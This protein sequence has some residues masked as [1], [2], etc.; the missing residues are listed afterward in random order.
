MMYLCG[1]T[2]EYIAR[3]LGIPRKTAEGWIKKRKELAPD[4]FEQIRR[5]IKV[6]FIEEAGSIIDKGLKLINRRFDRAIE[7]EEEMGK[8]VD[9]I[10]QA[11]TAGNVDTHQAKA[12]I[13]IISKVY[14]PALKD[15]TTAVGTLYDKRAL[16]KGQPTEHMA[17]TAE[18]KA[19]FQSV[20]RIYD[21]VGG[22]E[23][24][25]TEN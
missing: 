11:V 14:V 16:A 22:D 9:A 15:I 5:R 8:A 10:V 13:G 6:D 20:Q 19:L 4:E 7:D 23:S 17:I 18:D 24:E 21:K 3:E 2:V 25:R 1:N 12:A